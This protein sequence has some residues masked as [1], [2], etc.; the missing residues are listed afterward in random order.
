MTD[1]YKYRSKRKDLHN[2]NSLCPHRIVDT[3]DVLLKVRLNQKLKYR[4]MELS[5]E[6]GLSASEM[7][8]LLWIDYFK[9]VEDINWKEEIKDW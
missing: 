8:R 9:K 6:K 7:T 1:Y 3:K 2:G 5:K 4:I